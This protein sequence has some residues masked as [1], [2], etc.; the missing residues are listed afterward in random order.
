[1][2]VVCIHAIPDDFERHDAVKLQADE[3]DDPLA[4]AGELFLFYFF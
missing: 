2:V 3:V 1:M 4:N